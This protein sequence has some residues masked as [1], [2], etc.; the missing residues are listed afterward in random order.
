MQ[1]PSLRN[2]FGRTGDA[3][4]PELVPGAADPASVSETRVRLPR[5][6]R[7][8]SPERIQAVGLLWGD[9]FLFPGGE[10]ETL[11]WAKPLGLSAASTL[12]LL[13]AGGGGP[14]RAVASKL[15]AW[16]SG[17]EADADLAAAATDL[18]SR[19]KLGRRSQV[20]TW[21][22]DDPEFATHYYH[23]CLA[24]EPLRDHQPELIL[25]AI[26]TA[27]K[28]GGQ[29]ALVELIADTPLPVASQDVVHWARME[30]CR[31]EMLP[32][33]VLITR[34]LG[35]LGFDVRIVEDIS[36]R[37]MQQAMMG[38]RRMV[39]GMEAE[40]PP[41]QQ[42]AL[43]VEE[44]ELWLLRLKLFRSKQLRLVRW[45]AIGRGVP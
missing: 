4:P 29:L 43:L 12:L 14:A 25:T 16:V 20:E 35:R 44:A 21:E 1:M 28:P 10:A 26:A 13:G 41:I 27:L 33:E 3:P 40:R 7:I 38:W 15:G 19:T 17:F 32:T 36:S 31:P 24:L 45:H 42:S 37:H 5:N 39:R 8:W 6:R 18:I 22:P 11:R 2:W 34:M 9:G 30:H 23:H